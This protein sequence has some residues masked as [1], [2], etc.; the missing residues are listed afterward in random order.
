MNMTQTLMR[1]LHLPAATKRIEDLH[2]SKSYS[3][4]LNLK[5]GFY[6]AHNLHRVTMYTGSTHKIHT[7]K[8]HINQA[9]HTHP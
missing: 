6:T 9:T 5:T 8:G 1:S 4:S 2:L 3:E 7:H